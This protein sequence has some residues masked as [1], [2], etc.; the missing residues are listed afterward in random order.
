MKLLRFL[1][2]AL[3]C[4]G[5]VTRAQPSSDRDTLAKIHAEGLERSQAAPVFDHLTVNIGPRL[6]A[7]PA[8]KRAA[9]WTRDRL[10]SYGLTDAHLEPWQFGMGWTLDKL[11]IDL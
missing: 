10:A 8:H 2:V 1:T 7:S 3:I 11:T 5:V 6:T 9:E 4:A